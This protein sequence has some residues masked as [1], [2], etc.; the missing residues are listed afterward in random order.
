MFP[1]EHSS[2][3]VD[4]TSSLM[5]QL[6][7]CL[8]QAC[9]FDLRYL[10]PCHTWSNKQPVTPIAKKLDRL[11]VNNTTISS[12]P[13]AVAS[14][15]P[16]EMSDHS[17]CLLNLA[18][19]LPQAGTCPYRF[20]NY[21]TKHP[22]FA[23]LVKEAWI[24]AGS[25]CQTLSQLCVCFNVCRF[26]HYKIRPQQPFKRRETF[27]HRICQVRA[28]YNTIRTFLDGSGVW[29]TDPMEMSNL[30]VAHFCSVLGPI[31]APPK[32]I[33]S[34]NW[35]TGLLNFTTSPQDSLKHRGTLL[36]MKSP[37][38]SSISFRRGSCL[39][40]RTPQSSL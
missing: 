15:L 33:S 13:H 20:Q 19:S 2:P 3:E 40:L 14:F 9:L 23:Q 24:L 36:V 11:L 22:G 37:T 18:L 5:F 32:V 17:P 35:F 4:H 29:I 31:Y 25:V 39:T 38:P 1:F 16:P 28:S 10:G 34:H 8:L 12:Y 30:A 21:L 27:F 6:Q 7:D 26:R